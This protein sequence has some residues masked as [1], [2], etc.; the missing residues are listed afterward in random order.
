MMRKTLIKFGLPVAALAAIAVFAVMMTA[1]I[2]ADTDRP[3]I[4][5]W[6]GFTMAYETDGHAYTVGQNPAVVTRETHRLEF[7]SMTNWT[8]TVT[9]APT[10]KTRVGS[11]SATGSYQRMD[12]TTLTEYDALTDSTTQEEVGEGR[13]VG[14]FMMP[15]PIEESSYEFASTTTD[16]TVCFKDKCHVNAPGLLLPAGQDG[17][18]MVFVNDARGIPLRIGDASDGFVARTVQ[19]NDAQQTP[20]ID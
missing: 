3:T 15:F 19:I 16:A 8:D 4:P 1:R 18:D 11:F 20:V 2:G 10:I 7:T 12:G 5:T 9:A 13:V 17:S 14:P 6:P